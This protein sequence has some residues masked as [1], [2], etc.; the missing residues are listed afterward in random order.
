M[1]ILSIIIP[2]YNQEELIKKAINSLP[3]RDDLE[4]IV[5]DD[6]S[7]DNTVKSVESLERNDIRLITLSTKQSIGYCRNVGLD[8]AH[9]EFVFWLDSDDYVY[10]KEF[11]DFIDFVYRHK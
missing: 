8:A 7:T 4:I 9:G 2:V 11:E 3:V 10:T 1:A 5:I 6:A